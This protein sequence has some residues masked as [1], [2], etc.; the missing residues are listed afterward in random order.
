MIMKRALARSICFILRLSLESN[1]MEKSTNKS[2]ASR[3]FFT[4]TPSKIRWIVK[5]CDVFDLRKLL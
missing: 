1:D 2:V 4:Q 3:F 5:I